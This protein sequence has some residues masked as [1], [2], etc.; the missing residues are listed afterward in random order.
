MS[1][2]TDPLP[3][4]IGG[5][6]IRTDFR[7]ITLCE[8]L[9]F[10]ASLPDWMKLVKLNELFYLDGDGAT[11]AQT[12]EDFLWFWGGGERHNHADG[13]NN[14]KSQK[15]AYDFAVD[16]P[17][18]YAAFLAQYNIDLLTIPYLHWWQF[19]AFFSALT[20]EHLI[21]KIIA[22]RTADTSSMQGAMKKHYQKMQAKYA[23]KNHKSVDYIAYQSKLKDYVAKRL[24]TAGGG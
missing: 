11:P 23:L 20:E 13:G 21:T 14:L 12:I 1:F 4:S 8:E 22:Y 6:K 10:D 15:R 2:F 19:R 7:A 5:R 9:L 18:I 17:L 24:D 16:A 3:D